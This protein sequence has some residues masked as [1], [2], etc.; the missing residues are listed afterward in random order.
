MLME[1]PAHLIIAV[2]LMQC[3]FLGHVQGEGEVHPARWLGVTE[4]TWQHS[5]LFIIW[6]AKRKM[7]FFNK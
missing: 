7:W 4:P 5:W 3:P 2:L 1:G 6:I